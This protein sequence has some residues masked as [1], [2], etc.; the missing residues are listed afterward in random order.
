[1]AKHFFEEAASFVLGGKNG[2][3]RKPQSVHGIFSPRGI[4]AVPH[5]RVLA[6]QFDCR[7]FIMVNIMV[8]AFLK[9][10]YH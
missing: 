4:T 7:V 5:S 3:S 2:D 8:N 9:C 10:F 1:M 6:L